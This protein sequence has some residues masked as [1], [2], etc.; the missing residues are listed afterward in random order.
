[1]LEKHGQPVDADLA[2]EYLSDIAEVLRIIAEAPGGPRE[3][4]HQDVL[5]DECDGFLRSEAGSSNI[6]D[7]E[8]LYLSAK[9]L[10]CVAVSKGGRVDLGGIIRGGDKSKSL[11]QR[12]AVKAVLQV[13]DTANIRG[14]KPISRAEAYRQA[15]ELLNGSMDVPEIE[16]A[17]RAHEKYIRS[18]YEG[19]DLAESWLPRFAEGKRG[20]RVKG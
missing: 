8:A 10:E 17:F 4:W 19:T 6:F 7:P 14:G 3:R 12:D 15:A 5:D 20:P 16:K 11:P 13:A 18:M 1:M 9:V 2:A